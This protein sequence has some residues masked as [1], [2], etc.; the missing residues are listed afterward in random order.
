MRQRLESLADRLSTDRLIRYWGFENRPEIV[1]RLSVPRERPPDPA[2]ATAPSTGSTPAAPWD[3]QVSMLVGRGDLTGALAAAWNDIEEN[4][5]PRI[6]FYLAVVQRMAARSPGPSTEV[7]AAIDRLVDA[8]GGQLD[9][10]DVL[11]LSHIRIRHLG[12]RTDRLGVSHRRFTSRWNDA[13]GRLLQARLLLTSG[14]AYN[15]VSRLCKEAR[16]LYQ[17]MPEEGGRA[18]LYAT[19]YLCLLDGVAHIGAVAAYRND[20]FYNDAFEAFAR[21]LEL[22]MRANHESLIQTCLR[23]FGWLGRFVAA[24]PGPASSVLSTGIDAVLGS[25]GLTRDSVAALG[26]PEV[27]WYD[28]GLLFTV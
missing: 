23:W 12:E 13:T 9:E 18:G 17:S 16:G 11:R 24:V 21:A 19:A 26:V 20:S 22:A 25:H 3:E 15:Q 27:P 4:G 7:R 8:F 5:P 2:G 6:R 14:Q 1:A 28:E 10:S